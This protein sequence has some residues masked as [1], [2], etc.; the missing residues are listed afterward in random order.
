MMPEYNAGAWQVARLAQEREQPEFA[1]LRYT[2][3][4]ATSAMREG[5]VMPRDPGQYHT[6]HCEDKETEC[7]HQWTNYNNRMLQAGLHLDMLRLA[8]KTGK[9]DLTIGQH[10]QSAL[11][12]GMKALLE[13]RIA[14]VVVKPGPTGAPAKRREQK[15]PQPQ[16]T[17]WRA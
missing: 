4:A 13:A 1:V 2:N 7:E 9:H 17:L 16:A 11:E 6:A 3:S 15:R 10:A 5:I 14:S 8:Y 12:H